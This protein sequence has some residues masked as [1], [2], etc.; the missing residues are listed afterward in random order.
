MKA[1]FD[2]G[3]HFIKKYE[4]RQAKLPFKINVLSIWKGS[5]NEL[6]RYGLGELQ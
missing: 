6:A 3:L 5:F 2:L 4:A 1:L